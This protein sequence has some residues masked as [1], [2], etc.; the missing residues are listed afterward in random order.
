MRHSEIGLI[1]ADIELTSVYDMA[2]AHKGYISQDEIKRIKVKALVDSGD[3][4]K[5][6]LK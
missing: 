5:K 2:L 6:S 3:M 4:A 1:Y